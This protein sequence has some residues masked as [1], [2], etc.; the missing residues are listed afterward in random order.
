MSINKTKKRRTDDVMDTDNG[1]GLNKD[2]LMELETGGSIDLY[3]KKLNN[4]VSKNAY[5][6]S[7]HGEVEV[8]R[9]LLD[10]HPDKSS[11]SEDMTSDFYQKYWKVIGKDVELPNRLKGVIDSIIYDTQNVF[12]PGRLITGNIIIA[13]ELMHF[14]KIKTTGKQGGMALKVDIGKA[15][16]RVEWD[17]L[18]MVL[19]KM[20]F[21][22]PPNPGSGIRVVTSSI[23]LNNTQS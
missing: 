12:I 8:K 23:S 15:Y 5:G 3:N 9:A 16:D 6:A 11:G 17:F 19:I 18:N 13:H 22:T 10:M 4:N 1:L 2:V 14:M 21:V 20:G 7:I